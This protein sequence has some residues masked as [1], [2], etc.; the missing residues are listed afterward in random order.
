MHPLSLESLARQRRSEV[1]RSLFGQA[2]RGACDDTTR[3]ANVQR[4]SRRGQRRRRIGEP[5]GWLLVEIG[6][7]FATPATHSRRHALGPGATL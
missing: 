4:A 7:R 1:E 2:E 5:L 3:G 6:L